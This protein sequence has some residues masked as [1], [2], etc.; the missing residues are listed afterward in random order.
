MFRRE[1]FRIA[2]LNCLALISLKLSSCGNELSV[3]HSGNRDNGTSGGDDVVGD[4]GQKPGDGSNQQEESNQQYIEMYD[5]YAMAL[6]M[7]G[8]LGP[9]TGEIL[10][11]YIIANKNIELEFWHGH[12]GK[13]H[14]Y[15]LT[16]D[17]FAR[18][19]KGEKIT[20]ET[21]SV[22]GHTHK[23]FID[24]NYSKWRFPGARPIKVPV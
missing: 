19:K 12:G 17:H 20:V 1:F 6:Y 23:L 9:K 24:P 16:P 10:V 5:Q 15:A 11:E 21:T 3:Q 7:D 13:S 2:Y 18:L 22:D 8:G 14:R 4:G